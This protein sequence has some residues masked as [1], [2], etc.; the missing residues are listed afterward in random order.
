MLLRPPALDRDNGANAHGPH[1]PPI[2]QLKARIQN[3]EK[4][5]E[6]SKNKVKV[7]EEESKAKDSELKKR[8]SHQRPQTDG[9]SSLEHGLPSALSKN[10][11][12]DKHPQRMLS[13]SAKLQSMLS[14]FELHLRP[15]TAV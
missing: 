9:I 1:A 2:K 7:L 8:E 15:T 10:S 4:S 11:R 5:Y 6:H 12:A 13:N 14:D 3:V